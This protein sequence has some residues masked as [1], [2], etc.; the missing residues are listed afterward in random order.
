MLV[1]VSLHVT[2]TLCCQIKGHIVSGWPS[3]L[4]RQTQGL[5]PSS[6]RDFW[7]PKGGVGSNPTPDTGLLHFRI[8]LKRSSGQS[9]QSMKIVF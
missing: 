9:S 1:C 8:P 3:G 6:G 7:S 2:D 4:R 5:I